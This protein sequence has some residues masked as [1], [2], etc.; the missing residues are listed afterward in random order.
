MYGS[1]RAE[2]LHPNAIMV[3]GLG[4]QACHLGGEQADPDVWL[5]QDS[6]HTF[7]GCGGLVFT[8]GP[9]PGAALD[10]AIQPPLAIWGTHTS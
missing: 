6:H 8:Q 7:L 5:Q 1:W 4:Y 2:L 3:G 10:F 9:G